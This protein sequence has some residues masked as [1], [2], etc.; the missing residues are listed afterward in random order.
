MKNK[1]LSL[2]L[3]LIM[4]FMPAFA[5]DI[6]VQ[7]TMISKSNAQDRVWVGTFQIVW[8]EFI[9]KYVHNP[10]RF[11]EGT[12][13]TAHELNAKTF[14]TDDLS[15]KCY[16]IFSDNIRKNT[17]N[18]IKKAITKK[19]KETSDI[20]DGMNLIP[21]KNN[22]IVYAMLK[23]D[24]EFLR[25]FDKLGQSAFGK[26]MTAEYFGINKNS[27]KDI[28]DAVKVLY[29]NNP[30]DFAVVLYTKGEDEVYI[31]KNGANKEF[32]NIYRDMNVKIS[33][34]N[35]NK[36]LNPQDEL[37]IPNIKFDVT[38]S[39]DELCNKR[40]MGTN[41]SISKALETVKFNMD[42]KGVQLKS[43]AVMT[44]ETTA[45]PNMDTPEPRYFYFNDTFVLFLKEKDKDS[46]YFALRVYDI[47]NF[48]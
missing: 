31:Y 15:D 12:P 11:R 20:L 38:K 1:L 33:R 9:N 41:I 36:T 46:P 37:M 42:N 34:Y 30:D 28:K 27:S 3:M 13:A 40:V 16:Y 35:G 25:E 47:T 21:G 48:Q 18:H 32:K 10:V 24:F 7:P 14:D 2:G 17:V 5:S 19:F 22:F 8:N 45:A 39:F 44:F 6:E 26:D 43:E 4:A 23:K 29:Y